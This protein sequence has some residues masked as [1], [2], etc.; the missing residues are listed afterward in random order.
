MSR[1]R[2]NMSHFIGFNCVKI[3][4]FPRSRAHTAAWLKPGVSQEVVHPRPYDDDDAP[5]EQ[6]LAIIVVCLRGGPPMSGGGGP[7]MCAS[8]MYVHGPSINGINLD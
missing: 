6:Q 7:P 3:T 8:R 4:F 2:I 1:K 5:R